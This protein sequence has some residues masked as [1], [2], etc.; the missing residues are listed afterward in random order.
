[1]FGFLNEPNNQVV[2]L[3]AI[4]SF[5]IE[6]YNMIRS[7]TGKGKGPMISMHDAFSGGLDNWYNFARGADRMALDYHPYICFPNPGTPMPSTAGEVKLN[8]CNWAERTNQTSIQFGPNNA[9]E[10][11]AAIND[12]GQWL[13]G[14]NLGQRYDGTYKDWSNS[15]TGSCDMWNDYRQWDQ[16]TKDDLLTFVS[17]SMDALQNFFFW[18]WKIGNSTSDVPQPN[19]MW[20]Y[21]L[22]WQQGWIPRNPRNVI[23]FCQREA[24]VASNPFYTFANNGMTGG[25]DGQVVLP[26]GSFP[27]PP[28]SMNSVAAG[29]MSRIP[30]YTPT[31]TQVTLAGPTYTAPGAQKAFDFGSGWANPSDKQLAFAPIEGCEYMNEYSALDEAIPATACGAGLAQPTRRSLVE[32]RAP[33]PVIT[34]PPSL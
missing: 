25:A 15:R 34:A 5:Y 7:I 29:D 12:C 18:T 2:S 9:G 4:R 27:W 3:T 1:M 6:V 17:G 21:R 11:S 24:S 19:P 30:Q 14:V 22:G 28:A 13:N 31:A 16:Q 33:L 23:G 20:H 8:G 32:E 26:T 10:F